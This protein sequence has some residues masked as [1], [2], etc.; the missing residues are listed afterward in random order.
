MLKY[1]RELLNQLTLAVG[2]EV[3]CSVGDEVGCFVGEFVGDFEG[4]SDAAAVGGRVGMA[5]QPLPPFH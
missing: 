5:P 4:E 3:G 1:P 2:D